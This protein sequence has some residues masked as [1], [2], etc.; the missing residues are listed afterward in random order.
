MGPDVHF[1]RTYDWATEE[2][3]SPSDAELVARADVGYDGLYPARRSLLNISR[4]F[5][6]TAWLWARH[7]ER[8]AAR[9]GD[10]VLLGWALHC[11]QDA[12]AHGRLGQNHLL[13]RAGLRHNPDVWDQAPAGIR[14]RVEAVSRARLRRFRAARP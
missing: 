13:L 11:A 2:E 9:A 8:R 14:R 1:G 3:F 7:Y 12:V 4:H 10:L 5:A 6:P